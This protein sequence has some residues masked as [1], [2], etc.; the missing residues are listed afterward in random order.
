MWREWFARWFAARG[1][2]GER[3]EAAAERYLRRRGYRFLA[4]RVRSRLGELDLIMVDGKTV[5]FV[6]VKTRASDAAGGPEGAIDRDKRVRVTRLAAAW[7]KRKRLMEYPARF[8]VVTV[9]WPKEA[10]AP[11]IRHYP[12]AFEAE[13]LS[14]A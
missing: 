13:G 14:G 10:R 3:G 1:S 7:L 12:A 6:E 9:V 8:D 4:R 5:V 2:L 11:E